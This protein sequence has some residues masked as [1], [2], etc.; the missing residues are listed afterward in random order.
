[1]ALPCGLFGAALDADSP[2]PESSREE[3]GF[4]TWTK[5]ELVAQKLWDQELFREYFD[6]GVNSAWEGKYILH[7]PL[8]DE[9]FCSKFELSAAALKAL[10]TQWF[11]T[12][13]K[14]SQGARTEPS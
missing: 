11:D 4:Y 8:S 10:K 2:T 6:L 5:Q 14:S 7:R 3:G 12:L 13:E 1:M 9:E